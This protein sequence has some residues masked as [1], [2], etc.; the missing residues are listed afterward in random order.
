MQQFKIIWKSEHLLNFAY[1]TR[2]AT[3]VWWFGIKLTDRP[4]CL[5]ILLEVCDDP[6]MVGSSTDISM[7]R[8]KFEI[9]AICDCNKQQI[10]VHMCYS[11]LTTF[12]W[13]SWWWRQP[14]NLPTPWTCD[15]ISPLVQLP[16]HILSAWFGH[17]I[18]CMYTEPEQNIPGW[19]CRSSLQN[20]FRANVS[21]ER[22][23]YTQF[24][25]PRPP[26]VGSTKL[27]QQFRDLYH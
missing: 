11:T 9:V 10:I 25:F 17:S 3:S 26:A 20:D 24:C 23:L 1:S 8:H 13:D 16:S 22:T 7:V 4:L 6:L 27:G 2:I 19:K 12:K 14:M 18:Q 15:V 21:H 5:L